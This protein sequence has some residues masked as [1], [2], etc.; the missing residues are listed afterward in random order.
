MGHT[1][2]PGD[3]VLSDVGGGAASCRL[4]ISYTGQGRAGEGADLVIRKR[5]VRRMRATCA[6]LGLVERIGRSSE[7]GS[8]L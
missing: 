8:Y 1:E 4:N 5:A 7:G 2:L 6:W 3:H